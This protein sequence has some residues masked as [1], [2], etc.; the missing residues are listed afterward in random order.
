MVGI[1]LVARFIIFIQAE[2]LTNDSS[3]G[4]SP[5]TKG[6]INEEKRKA[7]GTEGERSQEF[8]ARSMLSLQSNRL[9]THINIRFKK[10]GRQ[11]Q[12]KNTQNGIKI[13]FS[14]RAH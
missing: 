6:E 11:Q 9:H 8:H 4:L 5:F 1:V 3:D 7:R 12:Q 10:I 2:M 14:F 13:L